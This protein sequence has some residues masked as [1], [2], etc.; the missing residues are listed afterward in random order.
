MAK[1]LR[2]KWRR[3][4]R[5]V[6]RE[7]YGAKELARLKKTLGIDESATAEVDMKEITEIAT[8]VDAKTIKESSTQEKTN[9]DEMEVM[10]EDGK[11]VFNTKTMRDQHG[12]YPVWMSKRK[13][14]KNKK[15]RAKSKK[16]TSKQTKRLSRKEKKKLQSTIT[17]Q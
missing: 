13:I 6:K 14:M 17:P 8:V 10:D 9:A 16:A 5:A 15:G 4:C 7:R 11:R 3:K 1:S 12:N 2:S